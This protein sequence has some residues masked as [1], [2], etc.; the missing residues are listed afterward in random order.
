MEFGEILAIALVGFVFY[1]FI[2]TFVEQEFF[3]F[4]GEYDDDRWFITP[5]RL[6]ETTT[7]SS[8]SCW[9]CA[10]IIRILNPIGTIICFI[11]WAL[12]KW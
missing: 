2:F 7:M 11:H 6:K 8:F 1:T 5:W 3:S 10:I 12:D 4:Y 9:A